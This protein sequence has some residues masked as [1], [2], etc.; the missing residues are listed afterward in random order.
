MKARTREQVIATLEKTI[1]KKGLHLQSMV[2]T[3]K[4]MK[5][6]EDDKSIEK[7]RKD[8]AIEDCELANKLQRLKLEALNIEIDT[9]KE[10]LIKNKI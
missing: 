8:E 10:I 6:I 1:E 5:K 7:D 4:N 9:L 3:S 2:F